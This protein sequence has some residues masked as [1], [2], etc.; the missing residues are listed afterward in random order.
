[1]L[2]LTL[3]YEMQHFKAIA[4]EADTLLNDLQNSLYSQEDKMTAYAHQQREVSCGFS[5]LHL[6]IELITC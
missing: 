3:T 6:F 4:S 5:S 1:M 2:C